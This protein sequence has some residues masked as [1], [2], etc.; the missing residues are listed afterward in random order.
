MRVLAVRLVVLGVTIATGGSWAQSATKPPGRNHYVDASRGRDSGPGSA[1]APW[2]TIE[3]AN[4]VRP[5]SSVFVAAGTY[6][7]APTA[8]GVHFV[9]ATSKSPGAR[10]ITK[11]VKLSGRGTRIRGFTLA[12]GLDFE[13]G[14][15]DHLIESCEIRDHW[16]VWG[17][18][19]AAP[20][21]N[22]IRTTRM[23]VREIAAHNWGDDHDRDVPRIN[24]L[25]IEDCR[26]TV[27]RTGGVLWRW[28]G[29]DGAKVLRTTIRLVNGGAKAGDDASWWWIYVR[30]PVVV[31]SH[32]ILDHPEGLSETGPFAPVWR[33]S[34][35]GARIV[36]TTIEAVRGSFIFSPNTAGTWICSCGGHRFE[37][38]V[39]RAPGTVWFYQCPRKAN[40]VWVRSRIFAGRLDEYN[41]GRMPAGLT[42]RP[43]GASSSK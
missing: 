26:I 32:I 20:H 39:I 25:T 41:V 16:G 3:R 23:N 14:A 29:V 36:R 15:R 24:G 8:P 2:K 21:N 27:R 1:R 28:S 13:G 43:Y 4:R 42:V 37:D 17:G 31:D 11:T 38:V 18:P 33:D 19:K 30:R 5:G 12:E 22:R 6:T 7:D 9:G 35:W 40:D 10:I 34:T